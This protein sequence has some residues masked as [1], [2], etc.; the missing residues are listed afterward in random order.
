MLEAESSKEGVGFIEGEVAA[1]RPSGGAGWPHIMAKW[2]LHF[3]SA[4]LLH[5]YAKYQLRQCFF[6]WRYDRMELS[7]NGSE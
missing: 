3:S 4:S 5:P 6:R 1:G 7:G 2:P